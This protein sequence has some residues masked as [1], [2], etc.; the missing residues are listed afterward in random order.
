MSLIVNI[1]AVACQGP[2]SLYQ[3]PPW[4]RNIDS[5]FTEVTPCPLS[6]PRAALIVSE[7]GS[8]P[9]VRGHL[10]PVTQSPGAPLAVEEW[11]PRQAESCAHGRTA[12]RHRQG[13]PVPSQP[14]HLSPGLCPPSPLSLTH[15]PADFPTGIPG[16]ANSPGGK[17]I[18]PN[19]LSEPA[20][21][22]FRKLQERKYGFD[23]L[24]QAQA[25]Q[26]SPRGL[27]ASLGDSHPDTASGSTSGSQRGGAADRWPLS[28]AWGSCLRVLLPLAPASPNLRLSQPSELRQATC[29]S[30]Q[31]AWVGV[32][33]DPMR[34]QESY[35]GSY[36]CPFPVPTA[37]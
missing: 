15:F 18:C 30:H 34:L 24:E 26:L 5:L 35:A 1:P 37:W 7:V 9:G 3:L 25:P 12:N 2:G 22:H 21:T 36:S 33:V 6:P 11:P 8:E 29:Q 27:R 23:F 28:R 32:R 4:Y 14:Q 17:G 19:E 31:K 16:K 13:G 10:C 20:L